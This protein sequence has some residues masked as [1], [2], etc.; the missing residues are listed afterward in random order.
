MSNLLSKASI[1]L[2][3]TA[4]ADN[5]LYP[6][7]PPR[8]VGDNTVENGDFATDSDWTKGDGWSI[9]G[10]V[11]SCDGSQSGFSLLS[12]NSTYNHLQDYEV[13]FTI[14][15]YT[16]GSVCM[17]GFTGGSLGDTFGTNRTTT[18]TY[19]EIITGN[20]N[21]AL[22]IRVNSGGK[23]PAFSGSI[24]NVIVKK[25]SKADFTT[26][27]RSNKTRVNES[28]N[29]ETVAA[30]LPRIDYTGGVGHIL[31]EPQSTNLFL[32]SATLSTQGVTTSAASHTVS[33]YGTGSIT[34]SGTHSATINGT[35]ANNRVSLSF[36]SSSGTLTCTVSGSVTNAQIEAL[37]YATSYIPTTSGTVT[38]TSSL[39]AISGGLLEFINSSEGVLYV[40]AAALANDGTTR[41]IA[42]TDNSISNRVCL[43]WDE[44]SNVIKGFVVDGGGQQATLSYT[45]TDLTQYNKI[46]L[47]YKV[48][49][50]ALWVNGSEVAT[51][52]SG[53]MPSGMFVCE[54]NRGD[55]FE[56]NGKIKCLAVY[57]EALTDAELTCLTT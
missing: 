17:I 53:T 34:L 54:T 55:Q 24:D 57:K 31:F 10:G 41:N 19:T 29:V 32:N 40:E 50:M 1:L 30:E 33:F 26:Q 49:D 37:S 28:G 9:S 52:T 45:A 4:Y 18:G 47:K 38:R 35:G 21:T 6:L 42:L 43:E 16:S 44:T 23:N 36:T 11:A 20:G 13:T 15:S 27:T 12:Q 2:T 14:T 7:I 48:N 56:F 3:P 46:A 39:S 22:S 8:T 25:I 5:T 51:D